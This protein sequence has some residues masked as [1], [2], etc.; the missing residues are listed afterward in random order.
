MGTLLQDV[1]YG[2][3]MLRKTPV[4]TGVAVL[5]LILGIGGNTAIFTLTH[6]LLL[7]SL[8]V[9]NPGELARV[10]FAK[11]DMDFG[12]SGPMFDEIAKRQQVF[13]GMLAWGMASLT[14]MEN[15]EPRLTRGA[16]ASGDAFQTLGVKA[17]VGRVITP[18]DDRPG[19]GPDGW[20]AVLSHAYWE[21]HFGRR[22]NVLGR[23]LSVQG[24]PVTVVGVA[25][26]G[27]EGVDVGSQPELILPLEFE[28]QMRGKNAQ[29]HFKTSFWLTVMGRLKPGVSLAQANAD[30]Q[31]LAPEILS[32]IDPRGMLKNGFFKGMYLGATAGRT[33]RAWVR[34]T[35]RQP[36]WLL[37]ALV[38]VILL[39]CCANLAGLF[40]ARA[41]AR[42]HEFAIRGALGA[43]RWRLVRQ[44][45]VEALLVAALGAAGGLLLAQ[46]GTAAL[47]SALM[48]RD[49]VRLD[50]SLDAGVLLFT[51]AIT[52]AAILLFGLPSGL[53]GT[54]FDLARDLN[55]ARQLGHGGRKLDSI[56]VAGQVAL[57]V[58][59]VVAA[60]LLAGTFYRL[61][62]TYPGFQVSG[63]LAV[64]TD[65]ERRPEQGAQR[66]ALY[67]RLLER[68]QVMPGIQAA[69]AESILPLRGWVSTTSYAA[70]ASDGTIR[71]DT[72]LYY[73]HVG[74]YYFTA[75]GMRLLAGRD[76]LPADRAGTPD[77]CA[78]NR[79]AARFF[80]G[81]GSAVGAYLRDV[82]DPKAAPCKVIAVVEDAKYTSMRAEIPR[83]IYTPFAQQTAP[84]DLF[85]VIR[86]DRPA[87]A[88]ASVRSALQEI[89]PGTPM[90]PAVTM[91]E[92]LRASIGTEQ[93]MAMLAVFFAVLAIALALAGLYGLL[94]YRVTLRVPEIG[95]RMALG[96]QP[97]RV[98]AGILAQGLTLLAIGLAVG[99]AAA[100][101]LTRFVAALLFGIRPL[102][103]ALFFA[104][105]AILAALGATASYFPARRAA[106]VDPMV[107]LRYE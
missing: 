33:G 93:V 74:A 16:L 76:F 8:A 14:V 7:R 94:S 102:E 5:T 85:L 30:I 100:A 81:D 36:L 67:E 99:I 104:S 91:R 65:F 86:S 23:V 71:K 105:A 12:L 68:L 31:R 46:W 10:T 3:R 26:P 53:R 70:T 84:E 62:T 42:Q 82:D 98:L 60:A 24:T 97:A 75:R 80:F 107:A 55:H 47:V 19:G 59:L 44:L 52:V 88:L 90:L 45:L 48:R 72:N 39:I 22:P 25:P 57:S 87:V 51:T 34:D 15:G 77:V 95:I 2:L 58:T 106:K 83:T 103:P 32:I 35:Y 96:A 27:F 4:F 43:H 18:A 6:A 73:N 50:L 66:I 101:L 41:A 1:R 17:E 56:L 54:R 89:A 29:R 9:A 21:Q 64:P 63:V 49:A 61:L 11:P 69:S 92:Q 40:S 38:G 13:S 78:L 28:V 20:A 79:S 37:Q